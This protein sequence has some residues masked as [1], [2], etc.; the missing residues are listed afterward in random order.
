MTTPLEVR[1][2]L[3]DALRLDLVGPMGS[4]GTPNETLPQTPSRWYLTGFLVPTDA[5]ESQRSDPTSD[6]DVDESP[7]VAGIDENETPE[8]AAAR[9][10]YLPSSIGLSVL[11]PKGT[12]KLTATVRYGDYLRVEQE[13][14]DDG[15]SQWRRIPREETLTWNSV[16][17]F[18]RSGKV[19]R[20]E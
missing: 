11:I 19:R 7:P 14:G 9:R 17:R 20:A 13:E 5:D 10:S 4:L 6:D 16:T 3:I 18:P 2:E 12:G 15:P 8:K 1:S